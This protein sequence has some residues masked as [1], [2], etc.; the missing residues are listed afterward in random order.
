MDNNQELNNPQ[1]D[2][3]TNAEYNNL[4]SRWGFFDWSTG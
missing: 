2:R 4:M 1:F 3:E